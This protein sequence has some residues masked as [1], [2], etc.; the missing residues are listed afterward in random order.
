M[1]NK[2]SI[3]WAYTIFFAKDYLHYMHIPVMMTN[4]HH[5]NF[6]ELKGRFIYNS[7]QIKQREFTV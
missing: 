4:G 7:K 2:F 1:I 3:Y 5:Y 6:L